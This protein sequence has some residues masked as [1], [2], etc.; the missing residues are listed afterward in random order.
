MQKIALAGIAVIA[1]MSS[2]GSAVWPFPNFGATNSGTSESVTIGAPYIEA[3][4]PFYIA[5]DQ[6]FFADQGINVTLRDYDSGLASLNGMLS[7]DVDLSLPG[8]YVAASYVLKHE[9]ISMIACYDKVQFTFIIGRKDRGITDPTDLKGK[10]IGLARKTSQEFYLGRF[11]YL[12][13]IDLQD[14]TLVNI[15]IPQAMNA[16][17][18]DDVDAVICIPLY[19][20]TISDSLGNNAIIW[21]AQSGQD[22]FGLIA[23]RADWLSQHPD[24]VDR[25]LKSLDQAEE[26]IISHPPEAN[27]IVQKKLNYSDVYMEIVWQQNQFSLSLDQSLISA[28]EDEARW[29]IKNNLTAEKQVPNFLDYIYEDGLKAIKPEAVNIIR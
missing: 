25:L 10:R 16:I 24:L 8:D 9:N 20:N 4:A 3:S 5:S 23:G 12:H 14:V 6:G 17:K 29:M 1:I 2:I 28:M 19:A 26:Y 22:S 11:L 21:P 7:G 27:A 15:S 18:G 13:G